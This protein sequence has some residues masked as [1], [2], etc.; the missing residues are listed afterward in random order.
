M[1]YKTY[2]DLPKNNFNSKVAKML[3]ELDKKHSTTYT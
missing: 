3:S 1:L 2:V